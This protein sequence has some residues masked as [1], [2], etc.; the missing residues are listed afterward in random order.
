MQHIR[1]HWFP[2]LL[3]LIILVVIVVQLPAGKSVDT[4]FIPEKKESIVPAIYELSDSEA[5]KLILYGKK[6]IDSTSLYFGPHGSIAKISNGLNCQNCHRESGMKLYTNNF[7]AV[8]STYPK[9]RPRSGM[10][11][12]VEF[13]VNECMQRS[14][15]GE[16]IDSLGKEMRAMVAYIKWTGKNVKK[17]I[18][19]EGAGTVELPFLNRAA[20]PAAGKKIYNLKCSSCHGINGEGLISNDSI[21][22]I[23]PPVWGDRSYAVSAGMFRLSR[24]ASFIKH[25]MPYGATYFEPQVS[26]EEAWDLAAYI[27]SQPHPMKMFAYDW[28]VLN[29]KPVDYPFGPYTDGFSEKQHKY[30]PFPEITKGKK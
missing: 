12:S 19:S 10:L 3:G 8:A 11:E 26:N 15:N 27:N 2:Y 14:M 25:N 22:F 18:N 7:L 28:P 29:A 4:F 17:G 24:L 20:D 21:G 1:E 13:R 5:D 16:T 6:L 9:F 23:Y 30:G